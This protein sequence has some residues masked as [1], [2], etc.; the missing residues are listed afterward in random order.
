M[1]N[2]QR[3]RGRRD[4]KREVRRAREE[5]EKS[6]REKRVFRTYMFH[7]EQMRVVLFKRGKSL[8]YQRTIPSA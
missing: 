6:K 5:Q 2:L 7:E 1:K 3:E 8:S 4:E